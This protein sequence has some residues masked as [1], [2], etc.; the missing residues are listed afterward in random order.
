M[1][2]AA[3]VP[4]CLQKDVVIALMDLSDAAF[5]FDNEGDGGP[6]NHHGGDFGPYHVEAK[7]ELG[8][9]SRNREWSALSAAGFEKICAAFPLEVDFLRKHNA[10]QY[11]PPSYEDDDEDDDDE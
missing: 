2:V 9:E 11:K 3:E 8:Y 7:K 6:Y 5:N 4:A 10:F 1:L